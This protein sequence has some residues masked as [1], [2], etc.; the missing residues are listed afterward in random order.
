M[1]V[2]PL[3]EDPWLSMACKILRAN[4]STAQKVAAAHLINR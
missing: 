1:V 3:E 4:T 2:D